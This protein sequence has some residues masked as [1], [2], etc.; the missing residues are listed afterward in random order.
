MMFAYHP[1][2]N[3]EIYHEAIGFERLS[4]DRPL[5]HS[6]LLN[7][8]RLSPLSN[9]LD[10]LRELIW[11]RCSLQ[12]LDER[13]VKLQP[14]ADWLF[15]SR[16]SQK[17]HPPARMDGSLLANAKPAMSATTICY[18]DRVPHIRDLGLGTPPEWPC[19]TP[20]KSRRRSAWGP[21]ASPYRWHDGPVA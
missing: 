12:L 17:N 1:A 11:A 9:G 7:R 3:T 20:G 21:G 19:S 10:G 14:F 4:P 16:R 13:R 18:S 6:G 8:T 2:S 5:C 15:T